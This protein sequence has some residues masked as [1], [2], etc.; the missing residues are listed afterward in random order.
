MTPLTDDPITRDLEARKE[1]AVTHYISSKGEKRLISA[2]PT[3]HLANALALLE[4]SE[5][6]RETE[7]HTMRQE[8]SARDEQKDPAP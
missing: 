5:P 1:A 7:I 2:M 8:L 4:R 6:H 3:R